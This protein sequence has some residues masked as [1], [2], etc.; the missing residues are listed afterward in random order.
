MSQDDSERSAQRGSR[1]F[2]GY[3]LAFVLLAVVLSLTGRSS[4][5]P[6]GPGDDD[7][8]PVESALASVHEGAE[9]AAQAML[10][11][12]EKRRHDVRRAAQTPEFTAAMAGLAARLSARSFVDAPPA[13]V[14]VFGDPFA[15]VAGGLGT[16][17]TYSTPA[18]LPALNG[19]ES[20]W[21]ELGTL[22]G[23][24][25]FPLTGFPERAPLSVGP[26][27]ELTIGISRYAPGG[28][29]SS[30]R[31]DLWTETRE[32]SLAAIRA[33]DPLTVTL[34]GRFALR[35]DTPAGTLTL[36]LRLRDQRFEPAGIGDLKDPV[37]L[38]ASAGDGVA[39][40]SGSPA[41]EE[42]WLQE[43]VVPA[44][45]SFTYVL[46]WQDRSDAGLVGIRRAD[47]GSYV[48]ARAPGLPLLVGAVD[49]WGSLEV[50]LAN[51]PGQVEVSYQVLAA[52]GDEE[53]ARAL[54][55]T[56]VAE[57][58]SKLQRDGA[59]LTRAQLRET[60]GWVRGALGLPADADSLIAGLPADAAATLGELLR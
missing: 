17:L 18:G 49:G 55:V 2:L 38:R 13:A 20:L 53:A 30:A 48:G 31:H 32:V 45:G 33:E 7:I 23:R 46:V 37:L 8:P 36:E 12:V 27:D 1:L 10:G 40:F 26:E 9:S 43:L 11:L 60:A 58:L 41:A 24:R 5:Q 3:G 42:R 15:G 35:R 16:N 57:H 47:D 52:S 19:D 28:I 56:F 39:R 50:A 4:V 29:F 22:E 25:R 51:V 6:P 44:A 34:S 21:L 14:P 59:P 54:F